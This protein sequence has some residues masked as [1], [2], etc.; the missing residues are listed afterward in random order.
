MILFIKLTIAH[1][2]G[3]FI[4]QTNKTI[5]EKNEKKW[6]SRK[7]YLHVIIHGLVSIIITMT[8]KP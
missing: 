4:F 2:V 3:D 1:I 8:N 6:K 5:S 7:L